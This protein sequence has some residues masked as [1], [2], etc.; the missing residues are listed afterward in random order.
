MFRVV[1]AVCLSRMRRG[2]TLVRP[3]MR[4]RDGRDNPA[5]RTPYR[6]DSTRLFPMSDNRGD[7]PYDARGVAGRH[8]SDSAGLTHRPRAILTDSLATFLL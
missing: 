6:T 5:N 8:G 4:G 7:S 2:Q 1:S 3:S